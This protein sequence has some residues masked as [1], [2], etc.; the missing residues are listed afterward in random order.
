M[1]S[2]ANH[3]KMKDIRPWVQE[4]LKERLPKDGIG[5]DFTMGNGNDTLY[6]AGS[7][8]VFL[9]QTKREKLQLFYTPMELTTLSYQSGKFS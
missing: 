6:M 2:L 8:N 7:A 1:D 4:T 9:E 3:R 5:I